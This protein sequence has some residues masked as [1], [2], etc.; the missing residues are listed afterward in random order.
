MELLHAFECGCKENRENRPNCSE[1]ERPVWFGLE[2]A[3]IEIF[4][5]VLT[6]KKLNRTN[7]I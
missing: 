5:S 2:I 4:G 6:F 3:K 7:I 1:M